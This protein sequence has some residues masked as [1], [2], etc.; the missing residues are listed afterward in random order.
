MKSKILITPTS[1][2]KDYRVID[3]KKV[4]TQTYDSDMDVF[5]LYNQRHQYTRKANL[6]DVSLYEDVIVEGETHYKMLRMLS[7]NE[8]ELDGCSAKSYCH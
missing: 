3:D 6:M 2:I 4:E 1:N 5:T 8:T 7:K